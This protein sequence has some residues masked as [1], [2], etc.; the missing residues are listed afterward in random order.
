[1]AELNEITV[2]L[3]AE[4]SSALDEVLSRHPEKRLAL[5][6]PIG[7]KYWFHRH[8]WQRGLFDGTSFPNSIGYEVEALREQKLQIR[9]FWE[10]ERCPAVCITKDV[11]SL[12]VS[13]VPK[14]DLG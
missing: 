12:S 14:R 10:C 5:W 4:G 3:L 2:K 13:A 6:W 9:L 1:M 11:V 7:W 8:R